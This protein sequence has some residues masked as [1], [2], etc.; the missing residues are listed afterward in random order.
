MMGAWF[1]L[2]WNADGSLLLVTLW[3]RRVFGQPC[4]IP[5]I[6]ADCPQLCILSGLEICV[7][8]AHVIEVLGQGNAYNYQDSFGARSNGNGSRSSIGSRHHT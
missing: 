2:L 7:Q 4:A 5:P 1:F 6:G 8:I 3:V